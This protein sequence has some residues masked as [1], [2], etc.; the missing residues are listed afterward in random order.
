MAPTRY[1]YRHISKFEF[2][3]WQSLISNLKSRNWYTAPEFWHNLAN[4]VCVIILWILMACWLGAGLFWINYS[5]VM[6]FSTAIM[7]CIFFI[8]HNFEGS[9]AHKSEDWDPCRGDMEGTSYLK[10]NPIFNWFSADIGYHNIH[11]LCEGIPSFQLRNNYQA[12]AALLKNVK[13]LTIRDIPSC[14]KLILWDRAG[15]QLVAIP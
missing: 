8:R 14:F 2:S 13:V 9:Y 6:T 1:I 11:H 5:I 4:N 3:N 7:I 10:I 15:R 12:N